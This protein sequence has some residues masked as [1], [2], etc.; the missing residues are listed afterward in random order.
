MGANGGQQPK[1]Q[2][3]GPHSLWGPTGAN[4]QSHQILGPHSVHQNGAN[5]RL[6]GAGRGP[7]TRPTAKAD[8]DFGTPQLMGANWGQLRSKLV[9]ILTTPPAIQMT[10]NI[11]NPLQLDADNERNMT[12]IDK[13]E[14]KS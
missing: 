7:M 6:E 14:H 8:T 1:H 12:Q 2:I 13:D 3:L 5:G 10:Y 4:S 9:Q 11:E